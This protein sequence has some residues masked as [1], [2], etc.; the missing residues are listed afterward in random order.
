M[1]TPTDI[2]PAA[3]PAL[4]LA[5]V[6]AAGAGSRMGHRPKGLLH[7]NGQ[8]LIQRTL[9]HLR[10]A[11]IQDVVVV[12]GEHHDALAP[13]LQSLG[14][15]TVFNPQAMAQGIAS[16]QRLGLA[17]MQA[18]HPWVMMALADQPLLQASDVRALIDAFENR[19]T[20]MQ[21][22][23]P[24]VNGQPGNP[25]LFSH[26]AVAEILSTPSDMACKAWRQTQSA[27]VLAWP[28]NHLGYVT[29]LDTPQDIEKLQLETGWTCTWPAGS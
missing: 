10:G 14:V 11:G 27:R 23:Y 5:V 2:E 4:G 19:P 13:L 3:P 17:Q 8:A 28:S 18:S 29:D 1:N 22:L 25:V 16:S 20:G 21:A 15:A 26:T 9:A 24:Q 7:I 6:L 12:L